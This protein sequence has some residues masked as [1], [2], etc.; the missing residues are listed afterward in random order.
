MTSILQK[1]EPRVRGEH[2]P[3]SISGTRNHRR[4]K[5]NSGERGGANASS[6]FFLSTIFFT[7]WQSAIVADARSIGD[8]VSKQIRLPLIHFYDR[9]DALVSEGETQ[10]HVICECAKA[11]PIQV[12]PFVVAAAHDQQRSERNTQVVVRA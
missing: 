7:G 2:T 4:F 5:F 12:I 6:A 10:N 8:W 3:G 9:V 11:Y 1:L